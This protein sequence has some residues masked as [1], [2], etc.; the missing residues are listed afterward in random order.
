MERK[1]LITKVAKLEADVRERDTL[2]AQ[3]ETCVGSMFERMRVL[4]TTNGTLVAH[5]HAQGGEMPPLPDVPD[6]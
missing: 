4:E 1:L 6:L 3:I 2:D 5:I